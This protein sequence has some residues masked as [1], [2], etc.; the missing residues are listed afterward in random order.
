MEAVRDVELYAL[1]AQALDPARARALEAQLRASPA[2]RLRYEALKASLDRPLAAEGVDEGWR[3][4]RGGGWGLGAGV[5]EAMVM[6]EE[7]R[8]RVHLRGVPDPDEH[9]LV[10]LRREGD[11][12]WRCV[13]PEEPE[14]RLAIAALPREGEAWTFDVGAEQRDGDLEWAVVLAPLD[15]VPDWDAPA[16]QR[17][18]PLM[19]ML[20][21]GEV[22]V[23]R[24]R[25]E[26]LLPDGG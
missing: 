5:E 2:L 12:P 8:Y 21:A 17:W 11:R 10:V 7:R 24:V 15:F 6:G 26:P 9:W 4:P 20:F 13:F 23:L 1:A 16:A 3:V 25:P 18:E 14:D 19:R 22:P